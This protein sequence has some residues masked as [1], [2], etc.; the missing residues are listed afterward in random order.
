MAN[1]I[2]DR[3]FYA[4][5]LSEYCP[6]MHYSANVNYNGVTRVPFGAPIAANAVYFVN[7]GT[8]GSGTIIS[9]GV[10]LNA[11]TVPETYGRCLQIVASGVNATVATVD[12]WDY[13]GQP[14]SESIT[15][16]G[17][18]PVNGNKAFKYV[19]QLTLLSAAGTVNLG[20]GAR[21]GLPYK[22]LRAEWE[23]ANQ[24]LAAA[25][26]LT[27]ADLTDP[28]T[29]TTGDP[30]GVYAPTTALNGTNVITCAFDCIND[31]NAANNGGLHGIAHFSN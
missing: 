24:V 11:A 9:S 4:R 25:G 10:M 7:A 3:S 19:R 12:G 16:N 22:A 29:A 6:A 21:L 17:A 26:T 18:T 15:L 5:R 14:M 28:A 8:P 1:T 27:A 13:L 20:I 30:R 2:N 31:V 23:T